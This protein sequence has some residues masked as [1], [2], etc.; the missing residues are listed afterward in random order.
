MGELYR[1]AV[2]RAIEEHPSIVGAALTGSH[3]R[4]GAEDRPGLEALLVASDAQAVADVARWLPE[5]ER[6]LLCVF[7]RHHFGSVLLDDLQTM[8]LAVFSSGDP[9]SHWE[10]RDYRL[11][12]GGE[13]FEAKLASAARR[14]RQL[15]SALQGLDASIDHVLLQLTAAAR[16]VAH[17]ELA[18]A[19]AT[20]EEACDLLIAHELRRVGGGLAAECVDLRRH[21]ERLAPRLATAVH[22]CLFRSPEDGIPVLARYLAAG[23][24]GPL[25]D[26]QGRVAA[27]LEAGRPLSAAS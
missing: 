24:A 6:I 18:S 5:P 11:I 1:H 17:G 21:L 19:H 26:A 14:A 25:T 7:R 16:R 20:L 27:Q 10:I 9:S 13:S 12:K 4:P 23:R 3:A 8:D 15:S 22:G 2:I